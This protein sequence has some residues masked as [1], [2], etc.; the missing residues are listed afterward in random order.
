MLL[1]LVSREK[2]N[3]PSGVFFEKPKGKLGRRLWAESGAVPSADTSEISQ[4]AAAADPL[5]TPR[6]TKIWPRNI[7]ELDKSNYKRR[8]QPLSMSRSCSTTPIH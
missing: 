4:M 2:Y 1:I 8:K 5:F 6:H 3:L 7:L